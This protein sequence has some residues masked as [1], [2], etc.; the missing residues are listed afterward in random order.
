MPEI[1]PREI[2]WVSGRFYR[3]FRGIRFWFW[4]KRGFYVSQKGGKQRML[5][6]EAFGEGSA[7]VLP[8]DGDWENFE[9]SNWALR[10]R[11][12][13]RLQK[14]VREFQE[15]GG[16]RFYRDPDSGYYG[17]RYPRSVFMHRYV[18]ERHN[19]AIPDG[20][21]VHHIDHDKSNNRLENLELLSASEHSSMH[22]RESEWVGS[23]ANRKQL[24][25]AAKKAVA[26]HKS[27]EGRAWHSEHARKCM[28]NRPRHRKICCECGSDYESVW[29]RAMFCGA[30]CK[31][32]AYKRRR[33]AGL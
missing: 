25:E 23:E 29:P 13:G 12:T 22:S 2:D 17:R 15:F 24:V 9:P 5:H 4:P 26:W 6:R 18:W 33:N 19:G 28:E 3:E 11:N 8:I 21:H 16:L 7:E 27:E 32:R 30:N 31:R 14:V 20:Y 1:G 10:K